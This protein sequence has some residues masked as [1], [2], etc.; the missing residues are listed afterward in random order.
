N[1]T[2]TIVWSTAPA[3]TYPVTFDETGLPQGTNWSVVFNQT[4]AFSTT[5]SIKFHVINGS[6]NF[7][8]Q[9]VSGFNYSPSSGNVFVNGGQVTVNI[10]FAPVPPGG[11]KHDHTKY[12]VTFTGTGLPSGTNWSV[13]FN[14]VTEYASAGLV[15][16][17]VPN[18]TYQYSVSSV[19]G[20]T[21]STYSGTVTVSGTNVTVTIVWSTAPAAT[22]PVTFDETG[23]P[24]GT[25]WSVSIN[26]LK[27]SSDTNSI[28][29]R[30]PNGTYVFSITGGINGIYAVPN[31]GFVTVSGAGTTVT[32]S[33]LSGKSNVYEVSVTEEGLPFG[34]LWKVS[35]GNFNYTSTNARMLFFVQNGT[36]YY[37]I[38]AGHGYIPMNSTGS[39]IVDGAPMVLNVGFV[40]GVQD[41]S[42]VNTDAT[43][44]G[45]LAVIFVAAAIGGLV[46][47][48]RRKMKN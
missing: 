13:T 2:V 32:V 43:F 6:Y 26:G 9:N 47:W 12:R 15:S 1:V 34:T 5:G 11:H 31:G 36:Y 16:F 17:T 39:F 27:R 40:K 8:I 25:N 10:V 44:G 48:K 33:W 42:A 24:Q 30:E 7:T 38:S 46:M 23:L 29:F 37:S 21:A 41:K 45:S 35:I 3:A 4:I 19:P 18:G 22:Y 14:D 20:Y 28:T